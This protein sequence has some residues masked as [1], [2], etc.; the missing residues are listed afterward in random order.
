MGRPG[1]RGQLL[2]T[3]ESVLLPPDGAFM[4]RGCLVQLVAAIGG[5]GMDALAQG[6]HLP[7]GERAESAGDATL[8]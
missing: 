8:S 3:R 4:L 5:L 7:G 2:V 1:L 6:V